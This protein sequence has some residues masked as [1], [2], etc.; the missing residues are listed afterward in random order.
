M[1]RHRAV[2]IDEG[3]VGDA[4][5]PCRHEFGR[6]VSFGIDPILSAYNKVKLNF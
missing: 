3:L 5:V 2:R 1:G 6:K 4:I